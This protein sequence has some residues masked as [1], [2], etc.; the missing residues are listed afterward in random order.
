MDDS[1]NNNQI[2][3]NENEVKRFIKVHVRA[4]L[5]KLWVSVAAGFILLVVTSIGANVYSVKRTEERAIKNES[6]IS[7]VQEIYER[8]EENIKAHSILDEKITNEINERKAQGNKI[9]AKIDK[10]LD[11]QNN[12]KDLIL[13]LHSTK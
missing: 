13:D 8:K 1:N 6:D 9:D 4:F 11:G 10:I 12:I 3:V 7:K 5:T 2:P